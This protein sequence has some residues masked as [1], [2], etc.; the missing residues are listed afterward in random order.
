MKGQ[1]I[2]H[3]KRDACQTIL[4]VVLRNLGVPDVSAINMWFQ[5]S[6]L[7]LYLIAHLMDAVDLIMHSRKDRAIWL[8]TDYDV[9]GVCAT[10]VMVH[11]L[12]IAGYTN[13]HYRTPK[14][15][16][17][18]YGM[19]RSMV[20]E[21]KD[22]NA[23]IITCDNGITAIDAIAYAK[24][25]GHTVIV[26][27]H[28]LPMV[29]DAGTTILPP[30]DVI[31]DPHVF[32]DDDAFRDYCGAGIAYRIAYEILGEENR[33][34]AL[35][36]LPLA[37]VATVADAV[38]LV[39]EN[40]VFVRNGLK[41]LSRRQTVAGLL[42][43]KDTFFL[44]E[45]YASHVGFQIGPCLNAPGRLLDHGSM[46]SVD[47]LLETD[48]GK[49]RSKA[50]AI[51]EI[52]EDRKKLVSD[53]VSASAKLLKDR[54][55]GSDPVVIYLPGACEGTVG[56]IAGKLA[57]KY[58][59][60]SLVFTDSFDKDVLK[61]SGRSIASVNLKDLLDKASTEFVTYGGHA[62]AAGM[63]VRRD[64]F[65][66]MKK[67]VTEEARNIGYHAEQTDA[68][69]YDLEVEADDVPKLLEEL[70]R[71]RPF[72][73]GNP[74]IMFK[75]NHFRMRP[76]PDGSPV[77]LMNANGVKFDSEPCSA[78]GFDLGITPP[79]RLCEVTMYGTLTYNF[80]K[81]EAYP[82]IE[83]V[84]AEVGKPLVEATSMAE[85]LRTMSKERRG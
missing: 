64:N 48:Y 15:I 67:T 75:V 52:N 73:E 16:T 85:R 41:Y 27:D 17:E 43:L 26:T 8:M 82:Q 46:L 6:K 14:R 50:L 29:D 70:G 62:G 42:A 3:K 76:M 9:D 58:G 71:F 4:E 24:E 53:A 25:K 21:I 79:D 84:D 31:I 19:K 59:V 7:G 51:K 44:S 1:T 77:R 11:A 74:P 83:L 37:A 69:F 63:S 49:A 61:G 80:F 5:R 60:P 66:H 57:E 39:E 32:A 13:V 12:R 47:L 22:E 38:P 23:L 72:G 36:L 28:H 34:Y 55:A 54:N 10:A 35:A 18:G 78:V 45:V 81:G 65:E 68:I 30:A 56:I 2:S 33:G 40:Y 20:D